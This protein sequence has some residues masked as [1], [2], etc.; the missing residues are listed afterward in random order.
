MKKILSLSLVAAVLVGCGGGGKTMVGNWSA[1]GGGM[2]SMPPGSKATMA[3]QDKTFSLN[4]ATE[5]TAPAGKVKMNM[6]FSGEYKVDGDKITLT[7]KDIKTKVDGD[8]S[9]VYE[10]RAPPSM[11]TSSTAGLE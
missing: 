10:T 2:D 8:R 5:Q 7:F 3:F 1:S 4:V 6:D 11:L 9:F